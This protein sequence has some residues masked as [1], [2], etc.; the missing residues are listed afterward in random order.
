MGLW[1]S[2]CVFITI[3]QVT[4]FPEMRPRNHFDNESVGLGAA[5]PAQRARGHGA[6]P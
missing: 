6:S 5:H 1:V 4:N 2:F 3:F